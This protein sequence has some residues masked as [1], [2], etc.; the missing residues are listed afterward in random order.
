MSGHQ[1]GVRDV[2]FVSGKDLLVSVS[3]DCTMKVW[4][5]KDKESNCLG[6]I[7]EHGGPIFT[8]ANSEKHLFS[9]GMEG[10][11]RAWDFSSVQ[12]KKDV[13]RKNLA[14]AW[15]NTEDDKLEPIWQLLHS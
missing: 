3:E 12:E 6:T 7:R 8:L 9:G 13:G 10:I 1:D 5:F 11:I 14:G 4:D 15:N 2:S